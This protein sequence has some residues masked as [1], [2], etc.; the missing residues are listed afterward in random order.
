[1]TG[2]SRPSTPALPCPPERWPVFSRL[3]DEAMALPSTEH[4]AWLTALGDDNADLRAALHSVLASLNGAGQTGFLT[5]PT[6]TNRPALDDDATAGPGR[7]VGPYELQRELGRGGMGRV[8]LARRV[9]GAYR[10]EV[11]LK[12][13]HAHLLAG[14]VRERFVRE[15]DIL[16]S[17]SH[18]NIA[19]FYDAGLSAEGQPYLA[20]ELVDGLP[21]TRWADEHRLR[22]RER[23]VLFGQV[24]A[25]VAH[26]HGQ[27]VA[28]RDLK[29]ANVLVTAA[30]EVRL[31]DF[32]IAKLLQ[33][34]GDEVSAQ[35][36]HAGASPATPAYA[37]PE[38]LAGGVVTVATDVYSLAAMLFELLTGS[39]PFPADK[40]R[41]RLQLDAADESDRQAPLASSRA[42]AAHA[43]CMQCTL[44]EL[45]RALQGDLDAVLCMAL[46]PLPQDRY[47]SVAAFAA[48][49]TRHLQDEPIQARRITFGLRTGRF[50]RR[51]RWAA[52]AS[53]AGLAA[54]LIGAAAVAWQ[55]HAARIE[56][57]IARA[58]AER[59]EAVNQALMLMFREAGDRGRAESITARELIDLTAKRLIASLD[60]ASPQ[61]AAVV[62]ALADLYTLTENAVASKALLE[63]AFAKGIGASDP[64]AS[65]RL[66]QKLGVILG[67]TQQFSEARRLFAEADRVWQTD[68]DRFRIEQ[69]EATGAQA[70]M[71]RLEGKSAEGIDLLLR[72]MPDAER[73]YA[74]DSRDLAAR[75][76]NL[77]T[78]LVEA[79]R[80]DEASALI[81]RSE[82]VLART[83]QMQSP[84]SLVLKH[85]RGVIA[86]RRGDVA[87]AEAIFRRTAETRRT[88]Y[89]R[90]YGL[91]VD[92]LR[93]GGTLNQLGRP[94][95]AL[96]VLDEAEPIAVDTF[97]AGS[98]AA[99]MVGLTRAESLSLLDR[100][101]EA[102]QAL[103]KV[104]PG[105]RKPAQQSTLKGALR[106]T[107]ALLAFKRG[108]LA[109]SS[110]ALDDAQ[111]IFAAIGPAAN[112]SARGIDSLRQQIAAAQ[113]R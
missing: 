91:A 108:D 10:R 33:D 51:H 26:A 55:A 25:A 36:T 4:E 90:S 53:A 40:R 3:L 103:A 101:D 75:Y 71:L 104:A 31:L 96:Q 15:R 37:A 48:D 28:H 100:P 74:S 102:E 79:N 6:L 42:S 64:V 66:K 18:P 45:R 41:P 8:W 20:L 67:A 78:H 63:S 50:L 77:V 113:R 60:P 32:G 30:G 61:S 54:L 89:G 35:L 92:L 111:A 106:K 23:L 85:Q 62:G 70:Y 11:A 94:A 38:Q 49:L 73:A 39:V 93:Q 14:A 68:R 52:S 21:I 65:A 1:M 29:P 7:I 2:D 9:D 22:I 12:L 109:A 57:D 43:E 72:N 19:R 84:A 99:L 98:Q 24:N 97:G 82:S 47:A 81:D 69:V 27:F 58:E 16:A 87:A 44:A 80:L 59:S 76:G 5:H 88:L 105:L 86:W 13:P 34:D 95:E 112:A 110:A 46:Q 56:R 107:E 17:L 83:G